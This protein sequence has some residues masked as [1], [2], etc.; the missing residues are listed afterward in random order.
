MTTQTIQDLVARHLPD[1]GSQAQQLI[2]ALSVTN[3]I[4]NTVVYGVYNSGKSS[5]LNSLT[6]HVE[7]EYFA[8]R[9]IPETRRTQ[10]LE[11]QGICYIDTPGLDIDE[12]DTA[13]ANRGAFQADIIMF[14]HKLSAG[15]IQQPDLVAMSAL[16]KTHGKP[17][18]IFLVI[19]EA[20][21]A[22]NS[23]TLIN[24][25]TE[26]V[27]QAIAPTLQPFLVSNPMFAKGIRDGKSVL[28]HKSGIPELLQ[29][30][31]E[32]AKHLNQDLQHDRQLKTAH[33]KQQLLSKLKQQKNKLEEAVRLDAHQ[34]EMHE[35]HFIQAVQALQQALLQSGL[36]Q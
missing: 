31:Q 4:P 21:V 33:L 32:Q 10:Q 23:A 22:D 36:N 16:A 12:H 7:A 18:S 3:S 14:V 27:Q 6:G 28:I 13:E 11:H 20:E 17:S 9:D 24:N 1:Q 34:Q 8:T 2:S 26:Q 15:P 35:L 25:I 19:T 5:L 29:Q 30:L